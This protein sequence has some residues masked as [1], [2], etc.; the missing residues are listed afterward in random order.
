VVLSLTRGCSA[1]AP[2]LVSTGYIRLRIVVL[3]DQKNKREHEASAQ[4]ACEA[5]GAIRTVASL[6]RENDCTALYSQALEEPLR[7]STR[8]AIYSNALYALS[9]AM[10]FFVISL[11]FCTFSLAN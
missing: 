8:T 11:I 9:Q 1:C 4:L 2:L 7:K 6:T 10:S 3:K 5:A